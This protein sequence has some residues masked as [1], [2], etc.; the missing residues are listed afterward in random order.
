MRFIIGKDII[1]PMLLGVFMGYIL[2]EKRKMLYYYGYASLKDLFILCTPRILSSKAVPPPLSPDELFIETH[3][4][5]FLSAVM[6]KDVNDNIQEI[7]YNVVAITAIL[8]EKGSQLEAEWKRRL[9]MKHTPYGNILMHYD[10][11]H[12][13]FVYWADT[14]EIPYG[15]INCVAMEYVV[16]YKCLDFYCDNMIIKTLPVSRYFK[17][18]NTEDTTNDSGSKPFLPRLETPSQSNKPTVLAKLKNY[19]LHG[20]NG[21][22]DSTVQN[23]NKNRFIYC[24]KMM[25]S[26]V[27]KL[28]KKVILKSKKLSFKEYYAIFSEQCS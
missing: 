12:R 24:G 14:K 21:V 28:P 23:Y 19:R 17:I 3:R 11:F 13:G 2:Y 22:A 1:T 8:G 6:N 4:V 16:K 27:F 5:R 20:G 25:D 26:S 15:V 18:W 7:Y 9:L 10:L